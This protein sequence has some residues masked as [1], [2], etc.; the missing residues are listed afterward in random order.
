MSLWIYPLHKSQPCHGEGACLT[1]YR[2]VIMKS[3]DKTWSMGEGNG[4]SL[5]CS[6]QENPMN[7]MKI[8]KGM[9]LEDEPPRSGGVHYATREVK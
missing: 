5:Q 2:Q 6:C 7:S 8:Q 4:K 9:T 1:Q 3:S